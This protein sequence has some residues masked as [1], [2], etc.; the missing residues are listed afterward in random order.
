[1]KSAFNKATEWGKTF[2]ISSIRTEESLA[3]LN[4]RQLKV[5]ASMMNSQMGVV[6]SKSRFGKV[7]SN[8]TKAELINAIWYVRRLILCVPQ[9]KWS[10]SELST[11]IHAQFCNGIQHVVY[12][13]FDKETDANKFYYWLN[14]DKS[15]SSL[16][17]IRP[18]DRLK[19]MGF[20]F[21]VKVWGIDST[22]LT[23]LIARDVSADRSFCS[24]NRRK[25]S[26]VKQTP[27]PVEQTVSEQIE[28]AVAQK[29]YDNTKQ[30]QKSRNAMIAFLD[31]KGFEVIDH[32]VEVKF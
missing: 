21:E 22:L 23:K 2:N 4:I 9:G 11:R 16:S 20:N 19:S 15:F 17:A 7:Y 26:R 30:T 29:M 12:F 5:V 10:L 13:G 3:L 32:K 24:S 1:M 31:R 27:L 14:S 6:I 8:M 28:L 18:A 25:D